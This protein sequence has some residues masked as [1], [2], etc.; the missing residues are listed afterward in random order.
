MSLF[1]VHSDATAG[2]VDALIAV[3]A[4]RTIVLLMVELHKASCC[5]ETYSSAC[6]SSIACESFGGAAVVAPPRA[7]FPRCTGL[8]PLA[9]FGRAIPATDPCEMYFMVWN[10]ARYWTR[11]A[12]IGR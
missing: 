10:T 2:I 4:M 9:C 5:E 6:L 1:N 12:R 8:S 11:T 7:R 3:E